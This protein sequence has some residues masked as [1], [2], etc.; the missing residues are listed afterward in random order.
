VGR[1]GDRE[2]GGHIHVQPVFD[3]AEVGHLAAD[4]IGHV[5]VQG[6]QGDDQPLVGDLFFLAPSRASIRF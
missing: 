2:A 5:A 3:I 4:Q 6:R 1:G